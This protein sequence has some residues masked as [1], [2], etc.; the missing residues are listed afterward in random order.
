MIGTTSPLS[1]ILFDYG[2]DA[3]C[4]AKV[5]DGDKVI[6]SISHGATFKEVM[7]VKLVTLT[8]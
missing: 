5:V 7:G 3:I 8:R 4:G 2:V 1:S 6:Q